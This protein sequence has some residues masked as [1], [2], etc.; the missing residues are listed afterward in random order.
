MVKRTILLCFFLISSI[1]VPAH[2]ASLTYVAIGD[3]LAAGQTPNREIGAGY[4]DMIAK[5][6][7]PAAYSKKL[8]V[9]GYTVKQVIAQVE[10]EEGKEAIRAAD[11]VTISAGANNLLPLIQNDP[12][13]GL[14]SFNAATA[15]FALN[16]VRQEYAVLLEKIRALNPDADVYAM[17]YYFPYPH[18]FDQ[19]K[20]AVNEQVE[21][22]N[23]IIKQEAEKAGADFVPVSDRFG[24]D[25]VTYVPNPGD[26]HPAPIGYLAMANA[27]LTIYAP[28]LQIPVSSLRK[29]PEP[30]S[31][32][33]LLK[34]K[35]EAEA[36]SRTEKAPIKA[37]SVK[38][39]TKKEVYATAL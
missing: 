5:A 16:G 4:A 26:V 11:L 21:R 6:L 32:N 20:P 10:S 2:A 25:A 31:F 35:E 3:S 8:S 7:Q 28:G 17:G 22:L 19:H 14:L 13:R 12:N 34:E 37:A 24:T 15:A 30:V 18:V 29:L 9:P 36:E 38:G 33:E 39:C 1:A 27:F 23:Q